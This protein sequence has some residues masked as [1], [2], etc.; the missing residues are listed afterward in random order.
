RS[1][2]HRMS[3]E[4]EKMQV[5]VTY[6]F[7]EILARHME[8]LLGSRYGIDGLQLRIGTIACLTLIADQLDREEEDGAPGEENTAQVLESRLAEL[9]LR[10]NDKVQ[11]LIREMVEKG[12][13]LADEQGRLSG[14]KPAVSM[15]RLLE[16]VFPKLPGKTLVAYFIQIIDEVLAGR[17]TPEVA[18]AHFDQ[19]L[20][21]Q[22]FPLTQLKTEKTSHVQSPAKKEREKPD[23]LPREMQQGGPERKHDPLTTKEEPRVGFRIIGS[24]EDGFRYTARGIKT[25]PPITPSKFSVPAEPSQEKQPVIGEPPSPELTEDQSVSPHTPTEHIP[26]S[27]DVSP[28]APLE[29]APET[30][31]VSVE[32]PEEKS[33]EI[34]DAE[35]AQPPAEEENDSGNVEEKPLDVNEVSSSEAGSESVAADRGSE[36]PEET[37]DDL[38]EKQIAGFQNELASLCPLCKEGRVREETTGTGRVYFKCTNKSCNLVS[39]G[40]PHHISCPV[41][42][43]PFLVEMSAGEEKCHLQCP[44]ATCKYQCTISQTDSSPGRNA[45]NSGLA[46]SRPRRRVVRRRVVKKKK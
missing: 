36:G 34:S 43:N 11:T 31:P 10:D 13:L 42:N 18:V 17:K 3:D 38:I 30:F 27:R 1:L 2:N 45:A 6:L 7:D 16:R 35:K 4:S 25:V 40:R 21:M 9:G 8:R 23:D 14:G 5:D 46:D 41:C 39:W 12:Y 22:G 19:T 26:E 24:S 15:A 33:G 28:E 29:Q 32:V 44:R 37:G 20:K